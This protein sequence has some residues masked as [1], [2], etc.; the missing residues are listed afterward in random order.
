MAG[1]DRAWNESHGVVT[2]AFD[3][4]RI[5][6]SDI[7]RFL[8][9]STRWMDERYNALWEEIGARPA[10]EY[11]SDQSDVF[12]REVGGLWPDDYQWMLQAAV[13]RDAVTAFEVYLEEVS[14]E[15]LHYHGYAWKLKPGHTPRWDQFVKLTGYMGVTVDTDQVR[16]VRAL[17]HTL[18]HMRGELRTQEQRDQF[19]KEDDSDFPGF[20]SKRAV[21]TTESVIDSLDD[22]AAVVR[23]VDAAAWRFS[24]GGDRLPELPRKA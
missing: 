3:G 11:D 17:R 22:L 21:L 9:L 15:V 18:T 4:W 19:G 23:A 14:S 8:T 24:Y 16:H 7:R 10:T 2:R 5:I 20:P 1:N 13:I 6:D 12:H